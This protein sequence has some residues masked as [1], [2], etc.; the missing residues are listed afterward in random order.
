MLSNRFNF[1]LY[2]QLAVSSIMLQENVAGCCPQYQYMENDKILFEKERERNN[3]IVADSLEKSLLRKI[4]FKFYYF[5]IIS[6]YRA[7]LSVIQ[8]V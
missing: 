6:L 3:E 1:F 4:Q 7:S 8:V 5:K 2:L